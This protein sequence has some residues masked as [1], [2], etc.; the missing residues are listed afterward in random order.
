MARPKKN[1]DRKMVQALAERLLTT[2]EIAAVLEVSPDTH[3]RRYHNDLIRGK[4]KGKASLRRKQYEVAMDGNIT[5]LI[6]LGKNMLGQ[7]DQVDVSGSL[8]VTMRRE[9]ILDKL[10]KRPAPRE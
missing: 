5:A 6:W 8:G 10:T 4:E 3:E 9:E 1:V 2:S 7:K